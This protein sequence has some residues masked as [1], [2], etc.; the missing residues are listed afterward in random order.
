MICFPS[1][2]AYQHMS[3]PELAQAL[4]T[5]SQH[6]HLHDFEERLHVIESHLAAS[7]HAHVQQSINPLLAQPDR[8]RLLI[9]GSRYASPTLLS[10]TCQAVERAHAHG[11][12]ILVGDAGGVDSAVMAACESLGCQ[13][14]CVGIDARPRSDAFR[15][16][17]DA[18]HG[19]YVQFAAAREGDYPARDRYLADLAHR[20]LC[21]WNGLSKGTQAVH[22]YLQQ[23]GKPVHLLLDG[24]TTTPAVPPPAAATVDDTTAPLPAVAT[25]EL[26]VDTQDSTQ[27]D[28]AAKHFH[29]TYGLRA[30]DT[31]GGV[32]H[33]KRYQ[34]EISETSND[35]AK[36]QALTVALRLLQT[37]LGGAQARYG[38]KV[39]QSSRNIEGWLAK[40]YKRNTLQVNTLCGTLDELLRVFPQT[41]WHKVSRDEVASLLASIR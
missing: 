27:S 23:L 41:A 39:V 26:I 31:A 20:G 11:W 14:V 13:Y 37:N 3:L 19:Y 33:Q 16:V 22:E 40:G 5:V 2:D 34:L 24:T 32:V 30:L 36:L 17:H 15:H 12:L 1:H 9:A 10:K 28:A 4:H 35:F 8:F 29:C 25:V 21:L 6:P 38:L 18:G 7:R